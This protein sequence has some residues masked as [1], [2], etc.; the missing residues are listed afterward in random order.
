MSP[1][2]TRVDASAPFSVRLN[3][4]PLQDRLRRTPWFLLLCTNATAPLLS[5]HTHTHPT[6]LFQSNPGP[7]RPEPTDLGKQTLFI[8]NNSAMHSDGYEARFKECVNT[9]QSSATPLPLPTPLS[10]CSRKG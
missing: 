9:G 2:P 8:T 4:S 5:C 1:L 6:S 3:R 7:P 10:F